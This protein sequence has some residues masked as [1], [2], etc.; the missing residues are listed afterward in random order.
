MDFIVSQDNGTAII[1]TNVAKLNAVNAPELKAELVLLNKSNVNNILIDMSNT[2][3]CDSSGLS[4][5]LVANRICK[6]TNGT[7]VLCGL[8]ENVLKMIQI[9]QLDKVF[10]IVESRKDALDT[11]K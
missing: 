11:I 10:T 9:A 8:N 5:I 4:A 2:T 1:E 7:F 3:Y 6:D